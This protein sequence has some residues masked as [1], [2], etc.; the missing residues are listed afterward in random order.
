MENEKTIAEINE[1]IAKVEAE[2]KPGCEIGARDKATLKSLLKNA[3][4]EKA[5][6]FVACKREHSSKILALGQPPGRLHKRRNTGQHHHQFPSLL[7]HQ[8]LNTARMSAHLKGRRQTRL[9]HQPPAA[10]NLAIP[11]TRTDR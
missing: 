10:E 3:G 9:Q 2:I 11:T 4:I 1:V 6:K 8:R 7:E 5:A